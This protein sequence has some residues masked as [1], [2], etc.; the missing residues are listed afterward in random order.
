MA[1]FAYKLHQS[2]FS[3]SCKVSH[4]SLTNYMNPHF[5]ILVKYNKYHLQVISQEY[6]K[7]HQVDEQRHI[8]PS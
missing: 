6:H 1:K 7:N 3:N 8:T 5:Q 4:I 2:T